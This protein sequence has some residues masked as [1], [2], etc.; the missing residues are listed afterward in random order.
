MWH[1]I[2]V[3]KNAAVYNNLAAAY[4]YLG[5]KEDS[6]LSIRYTNASKLIIDTL[7]DNYYLNLL[8]YRRLGRLRAD[9]GNYKSAIELYMEGIKRASEVRSK[10]SIKNYNNFNP[11]F[12]IARF[13]SFIATISAQVPKVTKSR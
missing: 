12:T 1:E 2:I 6:M 5:T 4:L 9:S 11:F 13:S 3:N 10:Y 8:P 7:S